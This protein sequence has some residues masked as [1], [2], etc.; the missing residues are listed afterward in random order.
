MENPLLRPPFDKA[1]EPVTTRVLPCFQRAQQPVE[2]FA[3]IVTT[4]T[5]SPP[6]TVSVQKK[7]EVPAM[8]IWEGTQM[9][10]IDTAYIFM[11][12]CVGVLAGVT[13]LWFTV[14][15]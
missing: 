15:P 8:R 13:F 12:I 6:P 1:L 4:S 10:Y 2:P 11:L 9:Q 5:A 14:R 3:E 7:P